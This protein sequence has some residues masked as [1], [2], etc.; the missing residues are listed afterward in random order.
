MSDWLTERLERYHIEMAAKEAAD[1]RLVVGPILVEVQREWNRAAVRI[2][3]GDCEIL[4]GATP[5]GRRIY[6]SVDDGHVDVQEARRHKD[7]S[8]T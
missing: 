7:G 1:R 6:L 3:V 4:I 2:T 5:M 8:W